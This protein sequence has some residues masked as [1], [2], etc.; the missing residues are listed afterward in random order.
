MTRRNAL[1]VIGIAIWIWFVVW[2]WG[3]D[4]E[5]REER[6][7]QDVVEWNLMQTYIESRAEEVAYCKERGGVPITEPLSQAKTP[8]FQWSFPPS[9]VNLV[10]CEL[11]PMRVREKR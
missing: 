7:A 4:A 3:L 9:A 6:K 5:R 2:L 1:V 10:R 8:Y 11:P